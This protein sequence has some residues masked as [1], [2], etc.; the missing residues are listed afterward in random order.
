MTEAQKNYA[1]VKKYQDEHRLQGLCV[2]CP[3]IAVTG[4]TRCLRCLERRASI[5]KSRRETAKAEG[6]CYQC[7]TSLTLPDNLLCEDCYFERISYDRLGSLKHWQIIKQ[8]F[9]EQEG[10]CAL[11]GIGLTLGKD[12][13]LDHIMPS[14]RNGSNKPCNVQWVLCVVNRMKD[15][16]LETEFFGLVESLYHTM[17]E[18][19]TPV[20]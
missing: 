5:R 13:E 16:M 17:K 6:F 3:A 1:R 18:R 2:Q 10:R 8:R 20:N 15:H 7:H 19:N 11:S 14:S 12:A 9:Y 4:K